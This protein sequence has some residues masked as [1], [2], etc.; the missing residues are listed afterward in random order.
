MPVAALV[1]RL[2]GDRGGQGWFAATL[3]L[4]TATG[5]TAV[6]KSGIDY[7]PAGITPASIRFPDEAINGEGPNWYQAGMYWDYYEWE[8][9]AGSLMLDQL[10][11]TYTLTKDERLL[12]PM[13]KALEL[14]RLEGASLGDGQPAELPA[15]SR[16]RASGRGVPDRWR[17]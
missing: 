6:D 12:Q 5:Y 4:A 1:L 2:F 9:F 10:L 13:F 14:I 3:L 8:H 15:G 16:A 17:R 7:A 11:F